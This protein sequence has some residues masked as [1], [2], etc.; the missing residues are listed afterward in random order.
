MSSHRPLLSIITPIYGVT[1]EF[2]ALLASMPAEFPRVEW[3]IVHDREHHPPENGAITPEELDLPSYASLLTGDADGATAAMNK[4]IGLAN[5]RFMLFLMGDDLLVK[6]G[7]IALL[8]ALES[9]R[10][11]GIYTGCVDFFSGSPGKFLSSADTPPA[12]DWPRVL[13]GRPC[14][15]PRAFHADLFRKHGVFDTDYTYCSDREFLGRLLIADVR[16]RSVPVPLYRY[17]VHKRS[18]TMGGNADRIA[19]YIAQHRLLSD[20]WRRRH[21]GS[22]CDRF[23]VWQAY[24]TGRLCYFLTVSGRPLRAIFAFLRQTVEN[25]GWLLRLRRGRKMARA[26]AKSDSALGP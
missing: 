6:S 2:V 5:G 3:I 20:D 7:I 4:G 9:D 19:R 15:G 1:R 16:E 12:L 18:Q 25:P 24:E 11:V 22:A 26:L 10:T 21:M 23:I 17:R 8:D 14:L 13:Y